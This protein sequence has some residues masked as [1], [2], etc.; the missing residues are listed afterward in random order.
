MD[1]GIPFEDKMVGRDGF[2]TDEIVRYKYS[3]TTL[4][5]DYRKK[6]DTSYCR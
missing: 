6:I 1:K 3:V 5:G 2:N 4:E